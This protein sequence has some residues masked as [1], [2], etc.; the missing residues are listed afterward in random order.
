MKH[1]TKFTLI[2]TAIGLLI[3]FNFQGWLES[4]KSLVYR[5][6]SPFQKISLNASRQTADFFSIFF[7]AR[8]LREQNLKLKEENWR[9]F[10][11]A[12][13]VSSLEQENIFLRKELGLKQEPHFDFI[14]ADVVGSDIYNYN[15]LLFI[16]KGTDDGVRTGQAAVLAGRMLVGLVK[17]VYKKNS[18]IET[19][20]NFSSRINV[21]TEKSRVPGVLVAQSSGV[22]MDLIDPQKSV[23]LGERL[24]TAGSID[25]IPKG[26]LAGEIAEIIDKDNQ[27]LKQARVS[28]PYN[29]KEIERVL[30]IK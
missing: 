4:S 5:I 8:S 6:F 20:F 16:N 21:V 24:L 25:T 17:D 2:F 11:E 12:A 23:A 13:K 22:F 29:I 9:L 3:F 7:R 1:L 27:I 10:S 28:V 19:I 26:L 18:K 15:Q 14:L 30:I